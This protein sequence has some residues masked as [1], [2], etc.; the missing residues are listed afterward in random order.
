MGVGICVFMPNGDRITI[1]AAPSARSALSMERAPPSM[2]RRPPIVTGGQTPGTAQLAAT[3]SIRLALE[4]ASNTAVAP[5]SQSTATSLIERRGQSC[6]GSREAITVALAASG[7]VAAATATAP[8]A[9][10]MS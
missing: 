10:S 7:T 6:D 2:K 4:A 8:A 3:A 1:R 5:L 9:R